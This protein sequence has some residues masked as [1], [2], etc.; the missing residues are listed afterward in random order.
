M[1]KLPFYARVALTLFALSLVLLFMWMG[2]SILI[3]LFFAF[4]VSILLHPIV[5]FLEK[6]VHFPR[7]LA[8]LLTILIFLILIAGLFYFFSRQV[9]R[10]SKD[11]PS[12]QAK[13]GDQLQRGQNWIYNKYHINNSEQTA[14]VKKSANGIM[15][16]AVNSAATTFV[17]IAEIFILTIFFFIFTFFILYYRRLLMQFL[18]A[19]FDDSHN[20]R[21]SG[22]VMNVRSLI[23]GYVRGLLMEMLV[24]LILIFTSLMILGIKYALL[25]AVLAAVLNIIPYF[26]IYVSLFFA[27]IVTLA[28]NSGGA[29][30][31]V[32]IVFLAAHFIDAN[33]VL[34]R[35]V[36]GQVKLNPFITL[37]AVLTGHLLWGVPG[38]FLFIPLTAMIRLISDEVPDLQPWAI[39]LGEEQHAK[40][41]KP[42]KKKL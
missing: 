31:T 5:V 22:I 27:V 11:L 23:N 4:L 25:L 13:V 19:L 6:K 18:L 1:I 12:L 36:G 39:L 9:I 40:K 10:L 29:A 34:P 21:V 3:P 20:A 15:G 32:G 28:S 37:L 35:I 7:A 14:Y 33:V 16:S 24:L 42:R 38:M 8:S 17:G 41:I 26:G 30:L 2:K